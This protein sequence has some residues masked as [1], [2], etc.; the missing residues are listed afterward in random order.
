M[1]AD[2]ILR[3]QS[4]APFDGVLINPD[5]YRQFTADHL[6]AKD[7][8]TNLDQYIRCNPAPIISSS[9]TKSLVTG[10]FLGAAA[11]ILTGLVIRH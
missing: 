8:E 4:P 7:F 9:G 6:K 10:F 11:I 1:P 2:T 5:H 3:L